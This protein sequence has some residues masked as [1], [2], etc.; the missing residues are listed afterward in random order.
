MKLTICLCLVPRLTV[1]GA[2]PLFLVFFYGMHRYSFT[3]AVNVHVMKVLYVK[4]LKNLFYFKD[5]C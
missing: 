3:F 2:V 1:S 5:A 4:F